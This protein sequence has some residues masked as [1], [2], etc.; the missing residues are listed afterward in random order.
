MDIANANEEGLQDVWCIREGIIVLIH[1]AWDHDLDIKIFST[2]DDLIISLISTLMYRIQA[3]LS[4]FNAHACIQI[5]ELSKLNLI[6]KM[7]YYQGQ[8]KKS[9]L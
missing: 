4:Y 3:L 7:I 6:I 2:F 1:G 9:K 5:A 8:I